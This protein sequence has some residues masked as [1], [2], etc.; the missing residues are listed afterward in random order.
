MLAPLST[1][2]P[3]QIRVGKVA[4][5]KG[6]RVDPKFPEFTPIVSLTKSTKYGDISPYCLATEDGRIMEN[7]WQ[8]TKVYEW[9]PQSTQKRSR[10]DQTVIWSH[11]AEQ[12]ALPDGN[13][14]WSIT[15]EYMAWRNK[16]MFAP[17]PVRYPVGFA[18][19]HKCLFAIGSDPNERL[20]YIESRKSI[21][22]PLYDSLVRPTPTFDQLK[23]RHQRGEN[24]LIIEVDGP[25]SESLEYYQSTYG[26]GSD[27]IEGDT[28][29]CTPSNLS[30]ML[31]D[32]K[33]PFGHGYCLA[34]SLQNLSVDS[35]QAI[36]QDFS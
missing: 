2:A 10:F 33:H 4:Y 25:H 29:L 6:K 23:A 12:H 36:Q 21:Y 19:R 35:L 20:G 28:M 9:V 1:P 32:P 5:V 26:V 24:L 3:G 34:M 14:G 16:L 17:D 13:G 15:N 8:A 18:H 27:F 30:I 7:I 11:P 31:E 22:V